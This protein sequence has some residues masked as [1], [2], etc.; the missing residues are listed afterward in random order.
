MLRKSICPFYSSQN[1]RDFSW[2]TTF[3]FRLE[4]DCEIVFTPN[5][6]SKM[7][8]SRSRV[9]VFTAAVDSLVFTADGTTTTDRVRDNELRFK[10][11]EEEDQ[12]ISILI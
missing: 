6:I 1:P 4:V 3:P 8:C 2:M 11:D 9:A 7:N 12:N 10:S 5:N